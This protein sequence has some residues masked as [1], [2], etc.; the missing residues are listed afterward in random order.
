MCLKI[1]QLLNDVQYKSQ[2]PI[3]RTGNTPVLSIKVGVDQIN[4]IAKVNVS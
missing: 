1:A 3:L 4:P 2:G